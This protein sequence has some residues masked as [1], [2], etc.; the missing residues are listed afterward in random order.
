MIHPLDI[1]II[2][3]YLL[4]M[5]VIGYFCSKENSNSDDY[6][7]SK[8]SIKWIPV[9]LSITATMISSST[10]IGAPGMSYATNLSA[11][12]INFSVPIAILFTMN[13]SAPFFRGLDITSIYDYVELRFGIKCKYIAL[14]QFYL[15]SLIQISSMIYIPS[16]FIFILTGWSMLM[17]VL[18][19]IIISLA[20]T[21][22]GGIKAV[23]YTDAVQSFVIIGGIL[24]LFWVILSKLDM[25]LF[26]PLTFAA[27]FKKTNF[28]ELTPIL[29]TNY[30][31]IAAILGGTVMW[32]RYFSFDQVQVQRVITSKSISEMKKSLSVSSLLMN[33]IYLFML[34]LGLYLWV[35]YDGREFESSNLMMIDFIINSLPVGIIGL[36]I[37]AVLASAMSSIDSILNSM[38]TVYVKHFHNSGITK[39]ETIKISSIFGIIITFFVMIAFNGNVKN[40]LDLVGMYISYFSGPACAIFM[41]G[42]F[43]K[44]AN[45]TSMFYGAIG[46]FIANTIV[47]VN[48]KIF[49]L[50]FPFLG[51]TSSLLITYILSRTN[52]LQLDR[53]KY[54]QIDRQKYIQSYSKLNFRFDTYNLIVLFLLII[55]VLIVLFFSFGI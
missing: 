26:E 33:A 41:I 8:G 10:L 52:T 55:Q 50:W 46:G 32:V 54:I 7:T 31:F 15:N 35:F 28:I 24:V 40:I 11:F 48:Y 6:L 30:S 20:Y 47:G 9:M 53:Q 17:I 45:D 14:F 13:V 49:W 27:K 42:L 22:M 38:T 18:V 12:T 39:L 3:I 36:I 51:F 19:I 21:I 2:I 37:S 43:S 23:I 5:V 4:A 29:T 1:T 44:K 25:N 34:F 16:L